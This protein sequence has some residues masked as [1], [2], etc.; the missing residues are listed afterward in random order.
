MRSLI[1]ILIGV[2]LAG[3]TAP[4]ADWRPLKGQDE[5]RLEWDWQLCHEPT[6][7]LWWDAVVILFTPV[8]PTD[9]P[10]AAHRC[11]ERGGYEWIGRSARPSGLQ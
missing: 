1:L 3:C 10:G 7:P 11:M 2:L 9:L 6:T 8:V 5:T 4:T